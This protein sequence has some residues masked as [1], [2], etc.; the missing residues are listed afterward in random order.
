MTKKSPSA[1]LSFIVILLFPVFFQAV[2]TPQTLTANADPG[3][4][5][6]VEF[7][8]LWNFE[9][10]RSFVASP[11]FADGLVYVTSANSGS[12]TGTLYCINASSGTQI[13][14]TTT[15]FQTFTVANGYVYLGGAVIP[16]P[17]THLFLQGVV[18]CLNAYDGTEVWNYSYGTSFATPVVDG[19][20]VYVPGFNYTLFADVSIGFIFA[21]DASTGAKKWDFQ[22]P[23]G[24]RFDIDSLVL[25]GGN[26]YAVSAVYTEEDRHWNSAVYAFDASTGEKLWNYSTPGQ[27]SSL[28]ASGQNVYVSSNFVNTTDITG[29][30]VYEG[31]VL[32]LNALGGTR[33]WNYPTDSSVESL[34]VANGTVHAVSGIGNVYALDASN[35]RVIWVY[36]TRLSTG[37]ALLVNSSLFVGSSTGVYCFD[38]SNGHVIWNFATDAYAGSSATFPVYSDGVVYVGWNGP[39]FFSSVTQHDFYALDALTG[40]KIGNYTLGYTVQNSPAIINST[41]YVGAS[42]VTEESPDYAGPGAV[43]ALNSTITLSPQPSTPSSALAVTLIVIVIIAV[44]AGLLLYRKRKR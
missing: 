5:R 35:G 14:N 20:I 13:W 39:Q 25:A 42:W 12:G 30:T 29:G 17:S 22:G 8:Q 4:T 7:T 31:G 19:D 32:A 40:E 6:K 34:I 3:T 43:V 44:A 37:P 9:S 18:S 41:V 15:L 28:V 16:E 10:D 33:I 21:F 11:V 27:F 36:P 26:L 2:G 24:T 23:I 38:A 1:T